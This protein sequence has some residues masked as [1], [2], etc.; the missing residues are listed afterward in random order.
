MAVTPTDKEPPMG[1]GDEKY[2]LL[3]TFKRSGDAVGTVAV[4]CVGAAVP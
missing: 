3:T 2:V 1:L 4:G